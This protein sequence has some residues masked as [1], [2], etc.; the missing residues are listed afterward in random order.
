MT[1]GALT[2]KELGETE[3]ES[4]ATPKNEK[5]KKN[6]S[7]SLGRKKPIQTGSHKRQEQRMMDEA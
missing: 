2:V 7:V 3:D 5:E 6:I 1:E 4:L